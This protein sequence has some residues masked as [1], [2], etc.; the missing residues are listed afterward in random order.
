[1]VLTSCDNGENVTVTAETD[2]SGLQPLTV[3]TELA[4]T[5][6]ITLADYWPKRRI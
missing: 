1:V 5:M 2:A 3:H 6:H 4:R